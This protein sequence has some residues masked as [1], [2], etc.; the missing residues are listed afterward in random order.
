MSIGS[1]R[2]QIFRECLAEFP[3][4]RMLDLG[5]GAGIFSRIAHAAGWDVVAVD[6]RNVRWNPQEGIE[7]RQQDVRDS[8]FSACDLVACLGLFYHLTVDDQVRLLR[9]CA[10]ASVPM[11]L[12][13]HFARSESVIRGGYSGTEFVEDL[14]RPTASWKNPISFW[15]TRSELARM[16]S[17][18]GFWIRM[19]RDPYMVDRAFF[20]LEPRQSHE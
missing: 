14:K 11:I 16:A 10:A 17:G 4:G 3:P 8:D 18:C 2:K 19:P 6:A 12:D 20:I 5:A 1:T 7:F 9:K 15:P 13:T